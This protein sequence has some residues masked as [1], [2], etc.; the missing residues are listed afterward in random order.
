LSLR[1]YQ[2]T[3][4]NER[5]PEINTPQTIASNLSSNDNCQ[6]GTAV[7]LLPERSC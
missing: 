2:I 6:K 3:I 5:L 7:K 4:A 1:N